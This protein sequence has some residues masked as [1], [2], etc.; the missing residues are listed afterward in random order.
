MIVYRRCREIA[1][2]VFHIVLYIRA[3]L[4][5]SVS[6]RE[7]RGG[8]NENVCNNHRVSGKT[9]DISCVPCFAVTRS[10]KL[11]DGHAGSG[12]EVLAVGL[13]AANFHPRVL[14]RI[15][16]DVQ[17]PRLYPILPLPPL[18]PAH[19]ASSHRPAPS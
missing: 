5:A 4:Q 2:H 1:Y 13:V 15:E 17:V 3:R 11:A 7:A 6:L 12:S 10:W 14:R 8:T 19:R 16:C 18:H 9:R